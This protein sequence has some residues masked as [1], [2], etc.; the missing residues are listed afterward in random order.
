MTPKSATLTI[1]T[2]DI[3][4]VAYTINLKGQH[5]A[6]DLVA[7]TISNSVALVPAFN[8]T[9]TNYDIY[10]PNSTGMIDSITPWKANPVLNGDKQPRPACPTSS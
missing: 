7:L 9:I 8:S 6:T 1:P 4:N 10:L 5:G 2:N 3:K